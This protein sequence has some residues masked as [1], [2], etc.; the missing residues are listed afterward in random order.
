VNAMRRQ[1]GFP[2]NSRT[3]LIPCV[4]QVGLSPKVP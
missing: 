1:R 4:L 2:S 3:L